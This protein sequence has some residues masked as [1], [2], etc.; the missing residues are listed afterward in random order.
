MKLPRIRFVLPFLLISTLSG[1]AA[2]PYVSRFDSDQRIAAITYKAACRITNYVCP[3][4]GMPQVRRS[5]TLGDN[6]VRGII[7]ND[8]GVV[9]LDTKVKGTQTWLVMLHE[10]IHW[11]QIKNGV[12][13]GAN[14]SLLICIMEREALDFTNEYARELRAPWMQRTLEEWR[15][16]YG[17]KVNRSLGRTT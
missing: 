13:A 15:K 17:C 6:G 16:L 10:Q 11:L 7:W 8:E 12:D 5:A 14:D 2:D 3:K 4:V 1:W 9:W